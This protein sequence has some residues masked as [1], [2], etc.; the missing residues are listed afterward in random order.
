MGRIASNPDLLVS[1]PQQRLSRAVAPKLT[2]F[3]CSSLAFP[4]LPFPECFFPFSVSAFET[5]WEQLH[6]AAS[7]PLPP[8]QLLYLFHM[9]IQRLSSSRAAV[10]S[11]V[12]IPGS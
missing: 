7:M 1:G 9:C 3:G 11:G 2:S 8:T 4:S 5:R 10:I 12:E 6:F